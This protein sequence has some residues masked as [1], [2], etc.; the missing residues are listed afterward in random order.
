[1][2]VHSFEHVPFEG[3]ASIGDWMAARG[4][5]VSHT[6][7]FAG[8]S[9]PDP[10]R[11]DALVVMGGPMSVNDEAE[12]PWLVPEKRFLAKALER[13][14]PVLGVCLGSQL[15][16]DAAGSRVFPNA[17]REIGWFPVERVIGADASP[18]AAALPDR[19]TVF[20]WHGETFDPPAGARILARSEGCALQAFEL[21]PALGLQFHLETT[22]ASA[23]ALIRHCADEI[24]PGRYIQS[25]EEML[26]KPERFARI[27]TVMADVLEAWLAP[28]A[29]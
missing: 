15:L 27:H 19:A 11:V 10:A 9:P 14:T 17:E 13:G 21:G 6:R 2:R 12:H 29:A 7:W 23:A 4:H 8:E 22:E 26:T 5:S 20:H 18:V 16:A 1:M 24:V 25:A 28:H 3:L